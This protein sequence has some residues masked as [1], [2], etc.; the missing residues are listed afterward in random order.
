MGQSYQ[1]MSKLFLVPVQ[2]KVWCFYLH[3]LIQEPGKLAVT[4]DPVLAVNGRDN[5]VFI[6]INTYWGTVSKGQND[7]AEKFSQE[8][9]ITCLENM[10]QFNPLDCPW[11]PWERLRLEGWGPCQEHRVYGPPGFRLRG[12]LRAALTSAG[13]GLGM[14]SL[15][16][17]PHTLHRL[18]SFLSRGVVLALHP[19]Y[20]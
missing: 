5:G 2:K 9:F 11:L 6:N 4:P 10:K 15:S 17:T 1:K 8:C 12:L 19:C 14:G 20:L 16:P 3:W 7:G 13:R 18:S